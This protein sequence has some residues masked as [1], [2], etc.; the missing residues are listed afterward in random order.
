MRVPAT[1]LVAGV[2]LLVG[3]VLAVGYAILIGFP[4]SL[5]FGAGS[6]PASLATSSAGPATAPSLPPK[7]TPTQGEVLVGAGDIA[8]CDRF[9]DEA[10]ADA[11]E[12][13]P[14]IVFTLGD[15]VYPEATTK[16]F[17]DCYTPSWGRPDIKSRTHP[18][19]GGNEYEV[20][21]AA[22]YFK[23]FGDAAGDPATGYYAYEAGA[24]RVYVLNSECTEIGGCGVNSAQERWLRG[25]LAAHP[26]KCV[27]AM[28]HSPMFSSARPGPV[29]V[30]RSMW[31]TLQDAG[32][33]VVLSGNDHAYERFAPQ[34]ADGVSDP[35]NGMVQFVVGTGG[36]GQSSLVRT[37]IP[38]SA[39]RSKTPV[40]GVLRLDLALD[41]YTW[42]FISTG[43]RDFQDTGSGTCH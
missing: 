20:D 1:P 35:K 8:E 34:D 25:D 30:M 37:L 4:V 31:Q 10:T 32:A 41:A 38:N 24:W 36:A 11:I 6:P 29:D 18:T 19:P 15:N 13:I 21:G 23:Y 39:I 43:G 5:P 14:G 42:T 12:H 40:F 2:A 27:L 22:D 16:Q 3:A 26:V 17:Q 7:P 9:Q 33:E 28:W